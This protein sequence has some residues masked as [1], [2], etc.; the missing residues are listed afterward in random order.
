MKM[1]RKTEHVSD[2]TQT[3]VNINFS[4]DPRQFGRSDGTLRYHESSAGRAMD[5]NRPLQRG[6]TARL[7]QVGHHWLRC[8]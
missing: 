1:V 2:L 7:S 4:E 8:E 3:V 5:T 6:P